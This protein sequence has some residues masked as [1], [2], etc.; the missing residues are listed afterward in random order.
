MVD[1][2]TKS[3]PLRGVLVCSVKLLRSSV[4]SSVRLCDGKNIAA[5]VFTAAPAGSV[6][7]Y[8]GSAASTL[9]EDW[10]VPTICGFARTEAHFRH[11][12]LG[13]SHST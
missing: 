13:D 5:T 4:A 7:F 6:A 12:S 1:G 8:G 9:A 10:G 11:L 3:T 2:N